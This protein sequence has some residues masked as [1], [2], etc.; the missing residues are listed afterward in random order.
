MLSNVTFRARYM[1][2]ST[3]FYFLLML[4]FLC[5]TANAQ[6]D[7]CTLGMG[8]KDNGIITQ[9]FQLNDEQ[10]SQMEY[11]IG[12]LETENKLIEDQIKVLFDTHPQGTHEE[13]ATMATKYK[14]LKD[15]LVALSTTYDRKLLGI[16]NEKQ[17]QRYVELCAEASR[18]P[19]TPIVVDMEEPE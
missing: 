3:T 12:E 11:W 15:Q 19:L 4:I 6:L 8:G 5:G 16:L 1:M 13:L 18:Q 2:K 7:N 9:V 14:V 10:I 17:Y